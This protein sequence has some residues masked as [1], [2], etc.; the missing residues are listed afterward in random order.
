MKHI[1]KMNQS[2]QKAHDFHDEENDIQDERQ[3][4]VPDRHG[5]PDAPYE[6]EQGEKDTDQDDYLD[7]RPA[8]SDSAQSLLAVVNGKCRILSA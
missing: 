6:V 1:L 2:F 7:K 4:A 5:I 8:P 3:S